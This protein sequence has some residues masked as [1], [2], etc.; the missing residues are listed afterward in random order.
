MIVVT[1]VESSR[2]VLLQTQAQ[3]HPEAIRRTTSCVIMLTERDTEGLQEDDPNDRRAAACAIGPAVYEKKGKSISSSSS[4][5]TRNQS[6]ERV[7]K[8]VDTAS[9]R[10]RSEEMDTPFPRT[11]TDRRRILWWEQAVGQTDRCHSFGGV[12]TAETNKKQGE[13]CTTNREEVLHISQ[14]AEQLT[15]AAGELRLVRKD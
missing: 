14:R 1:R 13:H 5:S 10:F 3:V 2:L 4:R 9:L 11:C 15:Q 6:I 8:T 7:D 12:H